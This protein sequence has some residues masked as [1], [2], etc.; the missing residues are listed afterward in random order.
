MSNAFDTTTLVLD[1]RTLRI[2]HFTPQEPAQLPQID[3]NLIVS[4]ATSSL[5][6]DLASDNSYHFRYEHGSIVK[7]A[8]PSKAKP[9]SLIEANRSALNG[10]LATR[11][12]QQWDK[13]APWAS[14]ASVSRRESFTDTETAFKT[15]IAIATEQ[16]E[17][18]ALAKEI[19]AITLA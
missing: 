13:V 18:D 8:A 1:A 7:D 6:P 2:I 11:L 12:R 4:V 15:R 9:Q 16:S 5:P 19:T 10:Q 3:G 14:V 17:I